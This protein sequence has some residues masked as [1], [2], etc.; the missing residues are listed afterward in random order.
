MIP[1][2]LVSNSSSDI[3]SYIENFTKLHK[4]KETDVFKIIPEKKELSVGQ[5]RELK[6]QLVVGIAHRVFVLYDF[7]RASLEAQ[8]ALLKSLEENSEAN[9]F[10]LV[11]NN[12]YSLLPTIRSRARTVQLKPAE[13][14]KVSPKW[15]KLLLSLETAENYG[16]LSDSLLNALNREDAMVMLDDIMEF[17]HRRLPQQPEVISIILRKALQLKT[18]LEHNNV[19]PQLTIDNLLIFI[20]KRFRMKK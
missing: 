7:H 6:K 3:D 8:N 10:F 1:I 15:E 18:F 12:E 9:S 13:G 5:I 4:I 14:K 19:N 16:F 11:T 20:F 17:Y 2:I